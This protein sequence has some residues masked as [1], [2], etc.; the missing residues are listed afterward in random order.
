MA[1]LSGRVLM[2]VAASAVSLAIITAFYTGA[3]NRGIKLRDDL[4]KTVVV[5]KQTQDGRA[6]ASVENR[7]KAADQDLNAE[8]KRIRDKWAAPSASE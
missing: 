6:N 8:I 1:F 4:W 5:K 7:Q 2:W 3:V